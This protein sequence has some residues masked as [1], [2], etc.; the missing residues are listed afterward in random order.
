MDTL[1]IRPAS[2]ADNV[3]ISGVHQAAIRELCKTHYDERTV[4]VWAASRT[5]ELYE[6]VLESHDVFVAERDG[7][8]VGFGQLDLESGA[9]HAVYVAPEAAR[10]GVGKAMLQ[11]LEDVASLHGW[12]KVHL[13]ATLNAQSFCEA[14]GYEPVAPFTY[15]VGS[16]VRVECVDMRK[17]LPR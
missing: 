15:Q 16:D 17:V 2:P 13:T 5:P 6:R 4:A 8:V 1:T 12:P 11:H 3:A 7:A 9:I 14:M 10:S